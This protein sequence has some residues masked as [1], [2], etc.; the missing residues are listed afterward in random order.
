MA[1]AKGDGASGGLLAPG[2]GLTGQ[3]RPIVR[4]KRLFTNSPR[5]EAPL[6]GRSVGQVKESGSRP[7]TGQRVV[8]KNERNAVRPP[9]FSRQ[10]A[11][12]SHVGRRRHCGLRSCI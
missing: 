5:G 10:T 9:R 6:A 4:L 7:F 3:R 11:R 8:L 12:R 1:L 2:E